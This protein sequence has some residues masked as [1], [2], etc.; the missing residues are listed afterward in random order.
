MTRQFLIIDADD[1]LWENN[2]Y[3]ESAFEEFVD[4]LDHS[5]LSPREVRDVLDEIERT[6]NQIHG[7]GSLNF[8]RNLRQCYEHLTEREI[9]EEDL[10]TVMGFARRILERPMEVIAGVAETLEYLAP[11]H[12][13]TLFTK[14]HPEE[15]KLKIDRSGLGGYFAH[16]AIVKEKHAG[17]YR[18]LVRD[19]GMDPAR[20]WMIGNSPKSDVNPAL[21]AGLNAVFVPHQHTWVLEKQ[22][23][24]P[25]DGRLLVL[26]RFEE[27]RERF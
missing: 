21:E 27:L 19:R 7:Y 23:I 2:I 12:D 24:V 25:G 6:N 8:G 9:R 22:E 17:A 3:F 11:R 4:F 26:E 15:Q 1:T 14:G 18:E 10:A 13:L 16:T 20:T 5:R